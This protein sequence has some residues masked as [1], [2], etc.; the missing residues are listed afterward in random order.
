MKHHKAELPLW[1][2]AEQKPALALYGEWNLNAFSGNSKLFLAP[3]VRER[4]KPEKKSAVVPT[5]IRE[6]F[7]QPETMPGEDILH[8]RSLSRADFDTD[9]TPLI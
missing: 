4:S 3:L 1:R 7:H 8:I 6:A 2:Y 9:S 5:E